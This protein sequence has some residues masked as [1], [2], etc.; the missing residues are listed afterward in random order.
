MRVP[1][2]RT[3]M[4]VR[5]TSQTPAS[6]GTRTL[7]VGNECF[8]LSEMDVNLGVFEENTPEAHVCHGTMRR[9]LIVTPWSLE[10]KSH[11]MLK[12]S[13]FQT[14][15]ANRRSLLQSAE[16]QQAQ[17]Q[18]MEIKEDQKHKQSRQMAA[19][20]K[21]RRE[22]KAQMDAAF[23]EN[24]DDD[25]GEEAALLPAKRDAEGDAG[26]PQESPAKRARTSP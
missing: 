21:R 18:L 8:H 13:Q 5:S 16:E 9:R 25:S 17:Q 12:R 22:S 26:A 10:T 24:D 1:R 20:E 19:V 7:Y 15:E 14:F 4:G 6:F 3:A 11:D 2:S 23:L